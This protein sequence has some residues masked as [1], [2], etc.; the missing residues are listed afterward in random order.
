MKPGTLREM[1]KSFSWKWNK[2]T[3]KIVKVFRWIY[4]IAS[5]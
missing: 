2:F 5:E 3:G 4:S 1:M